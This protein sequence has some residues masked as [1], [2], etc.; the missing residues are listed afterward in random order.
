MLN[1]RRIN[2]RGMNKRGMFKREQFHDPL[3]IVLFNRKGYSY[4]IWLVLA[5]ALLVLLIAVN[6]EFF[7]FLLDPSKWRFLR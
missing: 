4:I 5:L 2:K 1:K 3:M 6:R 7:S